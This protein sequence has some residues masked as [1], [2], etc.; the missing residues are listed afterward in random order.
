[1]ADKPHIKGERTIYT[2]TTTIYLHQTGFS[3][4]MDTHQALH[5]ASDFTRP[6]MLATSAVVR[7]VIV[8]GI[9]ARDRKEDKKHIT[10]AGLSNII[11][12]MSTHGQEAHKNERS[13]QHVGEMLTATTARQGTLNYAWLVY[14][15]F[16]VPPYWN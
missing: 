9:V 12:C 15:N 8:K 4:R 10:W 3:V 13:S 11:G 5:Q 6:H 16:F 2:Y 14:K 1:M 7:R